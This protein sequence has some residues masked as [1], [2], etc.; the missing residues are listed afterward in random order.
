VI[1]AVPPEDVLSINTL[2]HLAEV[3]AMYRACR[4]SA[5]GVPGRVA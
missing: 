1:D 2:E 3:D 4:L 5:E